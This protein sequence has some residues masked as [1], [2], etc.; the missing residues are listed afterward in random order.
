MHQGDLYKTFLRGGFKYVCRLNKG[1]INGTY[2]NQC[3]GSVTFWYGTDPEPDPRLRPMDPDLDPATFV[4]DIPDA[5]KKLFFS[6]YYLLKGVHLYQFSKIKSHKE[7]TKQYG[8]N[9]DFSNYFCLM[10]GGS[11]LGSVPLTN[12]SGSRSRRHN[13]IR[14]LR[15]RIHNTDRNYRVL[16]V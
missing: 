10:I 3:S 8:R 11:E 12:G 14:I 9:Q 1:T 6:A 7:V 13:Y 16:P 5:N 4:L 15:N 2:R